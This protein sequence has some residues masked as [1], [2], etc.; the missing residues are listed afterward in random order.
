MINKYLFNRRS[1]F[2]FFVVT[3]LFLLILSRLFFLQIIYQDIYEEK[4]NQNSIKIIPD[5]AIRGII[6]DRNGEALATNKLSLNL[7]INT[8]NKS[9]KQI[10][11]IISDAKSYINISEIEE[12]KF[13]KSYSQGIKKL[14]YPIKFNLTEQE[15]SDFLANQFIL[16]DIFLVEKFTRFYPFAEQ[17]AHVIGYI[18]R[19][20]QEDINFINQNNLTQKY[21]G[22]THIGKKGIENFYE[23]QLSGYPGENQIMVNSLGFA[24]RTINSK[25]PLN[26]ENITLTLSLPLQLK[27]NELL[28]NRKGAVIMSEI[29]TGEVLVYASQPSFNPN[30]FVNGIDYMNWDILN[31]NVNKPML[32]RVING[33]YPPGSTIKPFIALSAL[34]NHIVDTEY[35]ISDPGFFQLKN[36]K[37]IF[38]DWKKGGH[39]H[40]N[41]INAIAVS[42]DTFFYDLGLKIGIKNIFKTL[43]SFG[44]GSKTNI[45]MPNEKNGNL[46]NPFRKKNWQLYETINTSIGQ[47]ESLI[48]PAQ[49]VNALNQF[50]TSGDLN[51]QLHLNKNLPLSQSV[52]NKFQPENLKIIMQG[53]ELVT[54][55][56]GTFGSIDGKNKF[57]LAGKTGTAQVFSLKSNEEY[58]ENLIPENKRDHALFIGYAPAENPKV[59]IAVVI[60]N[61][62]HG[63]SAAAPIAKKLI[64][65]YFEGDLNYASN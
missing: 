10:S 11:K 31:N 41:I 55:T 59:S 27:A 32:D 5:I 12:Q 29:E 62:G 13:F 48:T 54:K 50:L 34:E 18:N 47:G 63:S 37:K 6:F 57:D 9:Y 3:V 26:G 21:F 22:S 1:Y 51:P 46:P 25:A 33:L 42:C 14:S 61:G 7:E 49:L 60:E 43:S 28:Q 15:I 16:S 45:D 30:L 24:L 20:N 64:D 2:I 40:V 8:H 4:S 39:G 44:F 56:G 65:S 23:L 36:S 52:K 17:F 53:M 35:Y 58:D 19:I 38:K